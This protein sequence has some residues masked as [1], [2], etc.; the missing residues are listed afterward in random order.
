MTPTSCMGRLCWRQGRKDGRKGL[1]VCGR[2]WLRTE[3]RTKIPS[4]SP[5]VFSWF[6]SCSCEKRYQGFPA[7]PYRNWQEARPGLGMRLAVAI[8][9]ALY[10]SCGEALQV[11]TWHSSLIQWLLSRPVC[12]FVAKLK[13]NNL[14]PMLQLSVRMKAKKVWN[15]TNTMLCL[16]KHICLYLH[17]NECLRLRC[18]CVCALFR[19]ALWLHTNQCIVANI[20]T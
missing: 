1:I 7:F 11:N 20:S 19:T 3:K 2:T 4:Y 17:R 10:A 18:I 16:V 8:V 6:M 9:A 12:I 15:D 13:S 5:H 14:L